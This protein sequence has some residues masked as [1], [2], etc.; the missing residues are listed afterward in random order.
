MKGF[1]LCRVVQ[2]FQKLNPSIVNLYFQDGWLE[3]VAAE[4]QAEERK[5]KDSHGKRH[6]Q[7][8]AMGSESVP[9]DSG[10]PLFD[11]QTGQR[12]RWGGR[13]ILS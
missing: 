4:V 11:A 1:F 10:F 3:S 9:L 6:R 2:I 13:I 12:L 5:F 7:V 8:K